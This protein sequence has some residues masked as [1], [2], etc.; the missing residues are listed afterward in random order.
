MGDYAESKRTTD[1]EAPAEKA[2]LRKPLPRGSDGS[3]PVAR[4]SGEKAKPKRPVAVDHEDNSSDEHPLKFG[5]GT[6]G[7][8]HEDYVSEFQKGWDEAR[9]DTA[10]TKADE[11]FSGGHG[12]QYEVNGKQVGQAGFGARLLE[13]GAA[14]ARANAKDWG[15]IAEPVKPVTEPLDHAYND[16]A[17]AIARLSDGSKDAGWIGDEKRY[18]IGWATDNMATVRNATDSNSRGGSTSTRIGRRSQTV[19]MVQ[20]PS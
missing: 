12:A 10:P 5:I 20:W 13:G 1:N 11:P 2:K 18:S 17:N 6:A 7:G 14:S 16:Q 9:E 3:K 4:R 15:L 19:P 8:A